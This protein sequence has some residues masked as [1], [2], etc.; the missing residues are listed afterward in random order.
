MGQLYLLL[1]RLVKMEN[2]INLENEMRRLDEIIT[3]ISSSEADLDESLKLYNEGKTI[4]EML[5]KAIE[6]AKSKIE[7]IVE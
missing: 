7:K 4:V 1:R 2:K 6:E 5:S 3:K